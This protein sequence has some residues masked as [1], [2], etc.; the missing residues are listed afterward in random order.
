M[1]SL[2]LRYFHRSAVFDRK[3]YG[4]SVR[5][6]GRAPNLVDSSLNEWRRYTCAGY[7]LSKAWWHYRIGD[8]RKL[9]Y[10]VFVG[11]ANLPHFW[12]VDRRSALNRLEDCE[13][14][15]AATA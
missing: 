4:A 11:R 10:E 3:T 2:V 9:R 8:S 13:K 1:L 7:G 12:V 5:V 14:N 6:E 15:Q